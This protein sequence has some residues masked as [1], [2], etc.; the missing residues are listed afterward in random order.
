MR[1]ARPAVRRDVLVARDGRQRHAVHVS[2]VPVRGEGGDVHPRGFGGER[3]ADELGGP[4]ARRRRIRSS[5]KARRVSSVKAPGE[6]RA[7][8]VK[9]GSEEG[10]P[11]E[12]PGEFDSGRLARRGGIFSLSTSIG[13]PNVQSFSIPRFLPCIRMRKNPARPSTSPDEFLRSNTATA[14]G[15]DVVPHD[16]ELVVH[17]VEQPEL[18]VDPAVVRLERVRDVHAAAHRPRASRAPP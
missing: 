9:E 18:L 1:P 16:R 11:E 6:T 17:I 13:T 8:T 3:A 14:H 5:S 7:F 10:V 15:V 12:V 4:R 2:D